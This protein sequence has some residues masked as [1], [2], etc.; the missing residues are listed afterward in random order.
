M[1]ILGNDYSGNV[2]GDDEKGPLEGGG[3]LDWR[4][5]LSGDCRCNLKRRFCRDFKRAAI[6]ADL[7][8]GAALNPPPYGAAEEHSH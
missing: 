5:S 1:T 3:R 8:T 6:F 7:V 4:T 2:G